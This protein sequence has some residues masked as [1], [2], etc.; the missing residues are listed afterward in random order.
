MFSLADL[1]DLLRTAAIIAVVAVWLWSY[2]PWR[3]RAPGIPYLPNAH[4][5]IDLLWAG[6]DEI[7]TRCNQTKLRRVHLLWAIL[8][9]PGAQLDEVLRQLPLDRLQAR[10][11][12]ATFISGFPKQGLWQLYARDTWVSQE[13]EQTL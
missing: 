13:L 4:D 5:E 3:K 12:V 1:P 11:R 9:T 6:M 2:P 8:S 7:A 10:V